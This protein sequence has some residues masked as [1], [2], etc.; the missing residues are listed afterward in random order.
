MIS[1]FRMAAGVERNGDVQTEIAPLEFSQASGKVE[2]TEGELDF[3]RRTRRLFDTK[4]KRVT[5]WLVANGGVFVL[6]PNK[7]ATKLVPV[8]L[9]DLEAEEEQAFNSGHQLADRRFIQNISLY[10][11]PT[12]RLEREH[13]DPITL[14]AI[15]IF[16]GIEDKLPDFSRHAFSTFRNIRGLLDMYDQWSSEERQHSKALEISILKLSNKTREELD[17]EYEKRLQATWEAPFLTARQMMIYALLQEAMTAQNYLA[18]ARRAEKEGSPTTAQILTIIAKDESYHSGGYHDVVEILYD[19]DPVGA[20]RDVLAVFFNFEMPAQHLMNDPV[21][22][23][24]SIVKSGAFGK[25]MARDV[26]YKT[27]RSLRFITQEEA[28]FVAENYWDHQ[29]EVKQRREEINVASVSGEDFDPL[30]AGLMG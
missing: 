14:Q 23:A 21:S 13:L 10:E 29:A 11:I 30:P 12:A 15:S 18:L 1:F 6:D 27:L 9:K 16:K 19:M 3:G 24:L 7:K 4:L 20:K 22:D 28:T 8:M 25:K 17:V 2:I 26:I 5:P